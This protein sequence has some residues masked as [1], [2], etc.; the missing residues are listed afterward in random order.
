MHILMG[1]SLPAL[2]LVLSKKVAAGLN[3]PKDSGIPLSAFVPVWEQHDYLPSPV[4]RPP[5]VPPHLW[6]SGPAESVA[7]NVVPL[8]FRPPSNTGT[9]MLQSGLAPQYRGAEEVV[10]VRTSRLRPSNDGTAA[11]R[12]ASTGR[13]QYGP[14]NTILH[15]CNITKA[16]QWD[17][18]E[19]TAEMNN[20]P[21]K[22][23]C[24]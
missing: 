22:E 8:S 10:Q 3:D 2:L 21:Q 15:D 18:T 24:D 14:R 17:S 6:H 1:P 11:G 5:L 20:T 12:L 4:H 13:V 23:R 9:S 7:Q 19:Y 16:H